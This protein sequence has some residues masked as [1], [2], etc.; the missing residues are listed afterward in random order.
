MEAS[1]VTFGRRE[2]TYRIRRSDRRTTVAVTVAPGEGVVLVAPLSATV[3]RLDRVVHDKA[4]W[5][6]D[7]LRHVSELENQPGAKE[8]VTGETFYYLG[9]SFRLKVQATARTDTARLERGW[10]QVPVSNRVVQE[11][12]ARLVR[13]ALEDWCIEKAEARLPERVAQLAARFNLEPQAVLVR[14]QAKRWASCDDHGTLRFNWRIIQAPMRLVDYVVAHELAHLR[15]KNHT[16]PYWALL[17]KVMPD[18][19]QRR[20]DLRVRGDNFIW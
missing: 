5:I 18:Y 19:E 1:V 14:Y 17:G 3:S 9:R 7:R 16:K 8:F 6:V 11:Q 2:I 10:L 20:A 15:H 13:A 4:A 12:R